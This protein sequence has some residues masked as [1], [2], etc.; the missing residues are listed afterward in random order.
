MNKLL[1]AAKQGA[2]DAYRTEIVSHLD[3]GQIK[4]NMID[5]VK[6]GNDTIILIEQI[7]SSP[8]FKCLCY[9]GNWCGVKKFI[10]DVVEAE[11]KKDQQFNDTNLTFTVRDQVP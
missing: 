8:L 1:S 10:I 3:M 9:D 5:A 2:E 7:S 4:N 6:M 11:F